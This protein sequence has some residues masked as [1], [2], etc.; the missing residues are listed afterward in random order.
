MR[1]QYS[2]GTHLY[3]TLSI[4]LLTALA[5]TMLAPRG[6]TEYDADG[7]RWLFAWE[8]YTRIVHTE[9]RG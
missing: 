1:M 7:I 4:G 9:A 6:P 8:T 2:F 3:G 5:H